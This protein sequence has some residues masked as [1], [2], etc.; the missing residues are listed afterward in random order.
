M[1]RSDDT[2]GRP[3][4]VDGHLY[5][6]HRLQVKDT[7]LRVPA[8]KRRNPPQCITISHQPPVSCCPSGFLLIS[9]HQFSE[10]KNKLKQRFDQRTFVHVDV[11]VLFINRGDEPKRSKFMSNKSEKVSVLSLVSHHVCSSSALCW[12]AGLRWW[13][14][15][16]RSSRA[17]TRTWSRMT[18]KATASTTPPTTPITKHI[19]AIKKHTKPQTVIP[20]IVIRISCSRDAS[21]LV[22]FVKYHLFISWFY[23]ES[24]QFWG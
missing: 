7:G 15:V 21:F 17:S 12:G 8:A 9:H 18:K 4:L 20:T 10:V 22:S 23:K 19:T 14:Q 2:A 5:P 6:A 1:N 16:S 13:F 24:D 3:P 11:C